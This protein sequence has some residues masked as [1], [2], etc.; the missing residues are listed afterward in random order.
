MGDNAWEAD[1]LKRCCTVHLIRKFINFLYHSSLDILITQCNGRFFLKFQALWIT[2]QR[3]V[4]ALVSVP[5][6]VCKQ[7]GSVLGVLQTT[8]TNP[9]LPCIRTSGK[10]LKRYSARLPNQYWLHTKQHATSSIVFSLLF[11]VLK[12]IIRVANVQW[13]FFS[14]F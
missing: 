3:Q 4:V 11:L 2:C 14:L 13:I 10:D 7:R 9:I 8:N 6:P 5:I 1:A 12:I